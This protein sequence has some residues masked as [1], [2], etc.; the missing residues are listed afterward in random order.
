[1]RD[2][3]EGILFHSLVIIFY[4]VSVSDAPT[5]SHQC[6]DGSSYDVDVDVD[7]NSYLITFFPTLIIPNSLNI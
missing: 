2:V 7:F 5:Y 6:A 4:Y 3:R 1:M